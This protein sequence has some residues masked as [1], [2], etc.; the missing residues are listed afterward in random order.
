MLSAGLG[1][2]PAYAQEAD[3]SAAEQD[4][5]A[6]GPEPGSI[7]GLVTDVLGRPLEGIEVSIRVV[8]GIGGSYVAITD[9]AGRYT[10]DDLPQEVYRVMTNRSKVDGNVYASSHFGEAEPSLINLFSGDDLRDLDMTVNALAKVTGRVTDANGEPLRSI[11]VGDA[12]TDDEGNYELFLPAGEHLLLYRTHAIES[13]FP[14]YWED[15]STPSD[16]TPI[17]VE[18][19]ETYPGFDVQLSLGGSITGTVTDELGQPLHGVFVSAEDPFENFVG[20]GATTRTDGTFEIRRLRAEPHVIRFFRSGYELQGIEPTIDVEPDAEVRVDATLML[21]SGGAIVGTVLDS[22]GDP[23]DDVAITLSNSF[24]PLLETTTAG[25]GSYRFD[26]VQS[27]TYRIDLNP[28]APYLDTSVALVQVVE[29]ADNTVIDVQLDR[30]AKLSGRI[31]TEAGEPVLNAR[32]E[33]VGS[34]SSKQAV[35]NSEGMYEV[36]GLTAGTHNLRVANSMARESATAPQIVDEWYLDAKTQA[37]SAPITLSDGDEVADL[38]VVVDALA[39]ISGVITDELGQPIES[40]SLLAFNDNFQSFRAWTNADGTYELAVTEGNYRL[41]FFHRDYFREYFDGADSAFEARILAVGPNSTVQADAVLTTAGT[42]SGTVISS[43]G[44]PI[45]GATVVI[46]LRQSASGESA[47]T[48]EHGNWEY[49]IQSPGDY[50][51]SASSATHAPRF[52][53]DSPTE[54]E[55]TAVSFEKGSNVEGIDLRLVERSSISGRVVDPDGNPVHRSRIYATDPSQGG[56][57]VAFTDEDGSYTLNLPGQGD[58]LVAAGSVHPLKS[59]WWDG[60][61]TRTTATSVPVGAADAV[62]GIDFRLPAWGSIAGRVTDEQGQ[63]LGNIRVRVHQAAFESSGGVTTTTDRDGTYVVRGIRSELQMVRFE[64]VSGTYIDWLH[65][66]A[67]QVDEDERLDG[68][69]ASLKR[70][71]RYG[72]S[73]SPEHIVVDHERNVAYFTSLQGEEVGVVDLA[74]GTELEAL[75]VGERVAQLGLTRGGAEV[76]V[77]LASGGIAFVDVATG[78]V[79]RTAFDAHEDGSGSFAEYAPGKFAIAAASFGYLVNFDRGT[80]TQVISEHVVYRASVQFSNGVLMAFEPQREL[81]I[82]NRAVA[83]LPI[84]RTIRDIEPRGTGV[85]LGASGQELWLNDRLLRLADLS[86]LASYAPAGTPLVPDLDPSRVFQLDGDRI[87]VRAN[88][89]AEIISLIPTACRGTDYSLLRRS[90]AVAPDGSVV[91]TTDGN[92]LCIDRT[93]VSNPDTDSDQTPD[94][95][96]NCPSIPNSDQADGDK[97]DVGDLCDDNLQDGPGGDLDGDALTNELERSL[98]AD[99]RNPDSDGDGA[100]DGLEVYLGLSPTNPD[101]DRDGLPDGVEL[102]F[103]LDPRNP[104]TDTGG[105]RDGQEIFDG[106]NPAMSGDDLERP[107]CTIFGTEDDDFIYGTPGDDVICGFGGNDIILGGAGDDWLIGGEG[108]DWLIGHTGNDTLVGD[109]GDDLLTGNDGDDRLFGG[110]NDDRLTGDAGTDY[111]NGGLGQNSCGIPG[112]ADATSRCD[113][114]VVVTPFG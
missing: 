59:Q 88:G 70:A 109:A 37:L 42:I 101:L 97:D 66:L 49:R 8:D 98:G 20:Q 11:S 25:D 18:L 55:A 96:D 56:G 74:T 108:T 17:V 89:T 31:L 24:G 92:E 39:R 71:E 86:V 94:Y 63:P 84:V 28:V 15:A 46:R 34:D 44:D 83:T 106:T 33:V 104:D 12:Q 91:V 54:E 29:G 3:G 57:V 69:N 82:L 10:R 19:D 23:V 43:T 100:R 113:R 26:G 47:T 7:S 61:P 95:L 81:V 45:V 21:V 22:S 110:Q 2:S 53:E 76:A 35:T 5:V 78:S 58:Y 1:I 36:S 105:I 9:A 77:T 27:G 14:E 64:D 52:W 67:V 4:E 30:E 62:S 85:S 51:V 79:E 73:V 103:R 13:Y 114:T 99:P 75:P 102:R 38:D 87:V 41:G 16:A 112:S 68:I 48:D 50:L 107:W 60:A 72:L 90:S 40:V 93:S 111:L 65:P 6:E 32:V 80:G